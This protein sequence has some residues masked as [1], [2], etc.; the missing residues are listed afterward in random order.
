[1][2]AAELEGEV[3]GEEDVDMSMVAHMSNDELRQ[4]IRALDNNIRIMKSDIN[5]IKHESAQQKLHIKD[6]KDKIKTNKALPYLVANVIEI[7]DP[8][9]DP[10]EDGRD[11][12]ATVRQ[13]VR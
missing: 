10:N 12:D 1:M 6:N 4:T 2:S 11:A 3:F 7:V 9:V 8:Y 13:Q 5:G